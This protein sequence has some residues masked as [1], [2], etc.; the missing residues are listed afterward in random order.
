[1]NVLVIGASKGLG[2]ALIE[3]LGDPGDLLTGVSRTTPAWLSPREGVQVSWIEADLSQPLPAVAHIEQALRGQ[4]LDTLI[5]NLGLWEDQAFDPAYDFLEDRD[6]Q[7]VAMV[8]CNVTA[9]ILLIKRLLPLL[10][11]SERPRLLLTGSTSGLPRSGRPEVT[12]GASKFALQGL[13]DAL[14]EGYR[15]QGLGV[16]CL[17]LGYLNTE[18]GLDVPL[19]EAAAR[20]EGALVPLHDVVQVVRTLLAL[21]PASYVRELTMPAMLDERF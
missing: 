14:R 10:L 5:Y 9:T 6:A 15:A 16:T 17:N 18:D 13:A 12:F 20:G 21:S 4:P 11:R 1:M 8:D 3:G 2:K 7:L 19:G